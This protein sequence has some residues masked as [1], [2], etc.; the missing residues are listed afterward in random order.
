MN[1][2]WNQNWFRAKSSNGVFVVGN[3]SRERGGDEESRKAQNSS[4]RFTNEVKTSRVMREYTGLTQG[5]G[6]L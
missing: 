4:Y 3:V 6:D 1:H 2:A 5:Y